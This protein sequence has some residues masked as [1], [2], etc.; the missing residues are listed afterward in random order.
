MVV[1]HQWPG[2]EQFITI[3]FVIENAF[4]VVVKVFITKAVDYYEPLSPLPP[5]VMPGHPSV[6][7][8]VR[9]GPK[10]VL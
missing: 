10:H 7:D 2:I 1:P 5:P 8:G 9:Y 6:T 3:T 4:N